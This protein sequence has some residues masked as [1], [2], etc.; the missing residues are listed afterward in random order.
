M[1]RRESPK[2]EFPYG[3]REHETFIRGQRRGITFRDHERIMFEGQRAEARGEFRDMLEESTTADLSQK[4][5]E[6]TL[7]VS[8]EESIQD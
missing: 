7:G 1:P 4:I 8:P 6:V 2:L 5:G 3:P